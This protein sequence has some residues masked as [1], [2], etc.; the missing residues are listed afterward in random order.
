MITKN[1][2]QSFK[3]Y[4]SNLPYFDLDEPWASKEVHCMLN[5]KMKG[6]I[7]E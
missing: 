4:K 5:K 7:L 6:G 2:T 3:K 1:N